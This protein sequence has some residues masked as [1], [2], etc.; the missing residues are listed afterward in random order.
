M[1]LIR[2]RRERKEDAGNNP[3]QPPK[4]WKLVVTL[5]IVLYLIWYLGQRS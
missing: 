5:A 2:V 4:M 3:A 1:S